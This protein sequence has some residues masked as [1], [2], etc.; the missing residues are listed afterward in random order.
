MG[1]SILSLAWV[2]LAIV[3]ALGSG[4]ASLGIGA[5]LGLLA[6]AIPLAM[7]WVSPTAAES[8]QLS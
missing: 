5:I 4:K 6:A 1:P 7:P 8:D 3:L 2:V